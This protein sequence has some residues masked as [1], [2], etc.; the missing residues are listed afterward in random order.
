MDIIKKILIFSFTLFIS[1]YTQNIEN[2]TYT[3]TDEI[4]AN[5]ERGFSA[6]R[7]E[8][9]TNGFISE[10]KEENV[11]VIQR[12][13]T[14]PEFINQ[15]LSDEFLSLVR[16]DFSLARNGGMKLVI[17]F[18]YTDY[19]NGA[20]APLD[21][22]LTH[23]NQLKPIFEENYDVIVYVEAGFIGAWG[24][25]YYSSNGLNN[26]EDRR[27]VL[28]ALLDALPIERDVV[29][30]T[31]GYKKDIFESDVPLDFN[32]AFSG[33][34][35]SRTGAHNDCFLASATDYGTYD[36]NDI[37]GDKDY[38]NLDNRFV[39]QGGETCTP[40]EYSGC[41]NALIDLNRM[42]WSV[43]NKDYNATVIQNWENNGCLD[44]IKRRLGYRFSLISGSYTSVVKPGNEFSINLQLV[45]NGFASP[46]NPRNL[47]FVI[48]ENLTHKRYRI[49]V[50]E[51]PRLWLSGDTVVVNITAGI[52]PETPEGNYSLFLHLPDSIKTLH[53]LP[54]YAIRLANENVWE[55]STGFNSLQHNFE[56]NNSASGN[57]YTGTLF[58]ELDEDSGSGTVSNI[59]IDG[60]FS[61]W[62]ENL[63]LDISP[64]EEFT[65]DALNPNVDLE[66]MWITDDSEKL[67]ISYSISGQ[68]TQGYFYH[69]FFDTDNNTS[70]GFHFRGSYNGIDL[71]IENEM[72]WQYT[73]DGSNWSWNA[74]GVANSA[75]NLVENNRIEMSIDKATL[76]NL[77]TNNTIGLVF[78]INDND[79]NVEDDFAP[80]NYEQIGFTYTYKITEIEENPNFNKPEKYKIDAYPNP[81]NGFI[82]INSNIDRNKIQRIAIYD[83]LG[84]EIHSFDKKDF[85][86]NQLVWNGKDKFNN[87]VGT[88][89]YFFTI[90]TKEQVLSKKIIYLK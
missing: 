7:S 55:D 31:P 41:E 64:N 49:K 3:S 46:F 74:I 26:T 67:Y 2:Y 90:Y 60:E 47:E 36:E 71:M 44:E 72:L 21:I 22:I 68:F 10:C 45:N 37:E 23:I 78:N 75:T 4:F 52:L 9:I 83:V 8:P 43:L 28:F 73:G 6:Y 25:W 80:N 82:K 5:P 20:D 24:E 1:V 61:D 58:F 48:R 39:P 29:I 51:D 81:F 17:R 19:Q 11:S 13:Y 87:S 30:R 54:E 53:N 14:I 89:V 86:N 50:D 70:T 27:T 65:G 77:G 35:K 32:E 16:S 57:L 38:L 76:S 63:K 66:D 85:I 12:I 34:Y 59:E 40:S 88:G 33:T 84:K 56:I 62:A 79:E 18:S 15:P 69:V 42:H